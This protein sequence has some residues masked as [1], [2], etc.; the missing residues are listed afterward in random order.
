[1]IKID[2][3][4]I[5]I[6]FL[7]TS[8]LSWADSDENTSYWV[9]V[10]A[11]KNKQSIDRFIKL[12]PKISWDNVIKEDKLYKVLIGPFQTYTHA[13]IGVAA[14]SQYED[15]FIKSYNPNNGTQHNHYL[16]T[17]IEEANKRTALGLF[18][19]YRRY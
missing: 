11:A 6:V 5:V 4:F 2:N 18:S 17:L 7:L 8:S 14:F 12:H 10:F 15:A 9:Q 1:M 13:N 19:I 16:A 3:L